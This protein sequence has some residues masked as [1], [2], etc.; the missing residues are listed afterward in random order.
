MKTMLYYNPK[1]NNVRENFG[2][3]VP[4]LQCWSG[5]SWKEA[6]CWATP[7]WGKGPS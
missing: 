3:T 6:E 4:W 7:S 5:S 1:L 2:T